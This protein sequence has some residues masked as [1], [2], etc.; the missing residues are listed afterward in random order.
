MKKISKLL[1]LMISL[2]MFF[3]GCAKSIEQQIAEQLE[4]GQRYL[5]EE[6]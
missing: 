6:N 3:T 5:S 1:V 4:L 2:A